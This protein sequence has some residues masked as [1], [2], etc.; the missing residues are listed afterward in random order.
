MQ[1]EQMAVSNDALHSDEVLASMEAVLST[2]HKNVAYIRNVVGPSTFI[3]LIGAPIAWQRDIWAC[4]K[5][6]PNSAEGFCQLIE[7]EWCGPQSKKQ[8]SI[9]K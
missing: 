3:V 1:N 2:M 5:N 8:I 7:Q 9:N 6:C 4:S